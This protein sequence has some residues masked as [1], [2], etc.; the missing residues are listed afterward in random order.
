MPE[1]TN[2]SGGAARWERPPVEHYQLG[3]AVHVWRASVRQSAQQLREAAEM[4]SD[5]EH[6]QAR[7]F[8]QSAD[9][10][11]YVAAHSVL[12]I[13]LGR[14]LNE[15]PAHIRFVTGPQGKPGLAPEFQASR[16]RFNLAHSGD[17][18]LVAVAAG[19]EVGVDVE[20]FRPLPE[21]APIAERQFSPAEVEALNS[22]T[23]AE[24]PA[25]F[26]QIW[27]CKEA[28]IKATGLGLSY[29]LRDFSV[30]VGAPAARPSLIQTNSGQG[31]G[32]L[33]L[34]PGNGYAGAVVAEGLDWDAA[35]WQF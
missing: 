23:E 16:I 11:R 12:R 15:V 29:P 7:R 22:L 30:P 13:I 8:R 20:Q 10:D 5:A 27:A 1:F 24:R 2:I 14:Y 25:A 17:W 26:F 31:W 4:L 9:R 6:I 19:R 35:L 3:G 28:F 32:L 18:A 21:A 33:G 34:A